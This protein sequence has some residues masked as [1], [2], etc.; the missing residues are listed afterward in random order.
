MVLYG[1]VAVLVVGLAWGTAKRQDPL[2][3]DGGAQLAFRAARRRSLA[4]V[5]LALALLAAGFASV[6]LA[7]GWLGAG[8][9]L[10]PTLAGIGGLALYAAIP[11]PKD[12][13]TQP[14]YAASLARRTPW[15]VAP[16]A[17][18]T[19]LGAA[20]LLLLVLLVFTGV[21]SSPDALGHFRSITFT[22]PSSV[23]SAGPYPG[24]FYAVPLLVG[25]PLLALAAWAALRRIATTASF[26]GEALEELDSVWRAR[27]AQIVVGL[28]TAAVCLQ[29]GGIALSA[30]I[31]M[32]SARVMPGVPVGWQVLATGLT[33]LG[34]ASL[35]LSIVALT[36]AALRAFA[37]PQRVIRS[38]TRIARSA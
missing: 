17:A 5:G 14:R 8:A 32:R 20:I 23:S 30:G 12:D 29:L 18:L 31:T 3:I 9:S 37:L 2:R 15:N 25:T 7:P 26:P 19:A 38:D 4:S 21:T 34:I 13:G 10:A 22:A 11:T 27:S 16:K 28:A 1:V 33:L 36:L 24:W 35:L 6:Q